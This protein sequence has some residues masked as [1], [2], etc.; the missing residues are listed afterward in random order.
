MLEEARQLLNSGRDVAVGI[1]LDHGRA[2]TREL[3]AGLENVT[4]HLVTSGGVAV[5]EMDVD[6]VLARHP[7]VAVVDEYA[8]TNASGSRNGH[9]WEDVA[10]LL[11]AGIDVLSTVSIQHLASLGDVVSAITDE[12]PADTVPDEIVRRADQIELVDIAPELLRQ[13]LSDGNIY[14]KE[15]VDAALADEFRLGN[16]FALR[17]IAL[18]WLAD[19]VDEGLAKYRASQGITASWPARER[20]V[21]GLTGGPEGDALIR[22]ASRILSRVNGGDL[23]AVHVRRPGHR[24]GEAAEVLAAQG[25]LVTD[26]GGSYH[27]VTGDDASESLLE[28]ARN[29]NATQIVVGVSQSGLTSRLM[30]S[31]VGA[32]VVRGSGDIDVHM[33]SHPLGS[34][35]LPRPAPLALGRARTTAGFIL[36]V[37]L[38]ALATEALSLAPELNL[39]TH[40]L[41]HL[42]G[43]MAVAFI[44]GLWPAV[45]AALLDSLLLNY[46]ETDPVGTFRIDDPQNFFALLVFLGSAIAV[47]LLVGLSA[48]RAR[49]AARARAEAATLAD[50]A[51]DAL[52]EDDT[53]AAFLNKVRKT[54]Q[55]QS[56]GL[57]TLGPDTRGDWALQAY[58]GKAAPPSPGSGDPGLD[59]VELA[60]PETALV[61]SGR[62]LTAGD[63]RLL[64]AYGSHLLLLRQRQSLQLKLRRTAKLAEGNSVRTSILRAVSHDL[65][66]P[67]AG[68]KLAVTAL[69]RQNQRLPEEVKAEMLDTIESYSDRLE[70]LVSNLLDMSRISSGSAAPLTAAVTWRDAIEDALRGVPGGAIRIDLA[71]NMPPI[72]ADLGMLERVIA[73][74]AENALKYAPDSDIVIVGPSSGSGVATIGGRPCGE[75]RIVDHGHGVPP[76]DVLAMFE[77]FQRLDDAPDGLGIGLGLAVAKGFTEAMGGQLAAE[78][79]PGGGLTVVIRLPLSTGS[80]NAHLK[81]R[82]DE[83]HA[84]TGGR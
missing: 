22:R 62:T 81:S 75:L 67:L 18:I 77:P 27:T 7:D 44:G 21:V 6:A 35:G 65:R 23:L 55:V 57:F 37:L 45:V 24:T 54:F 66:T 32:K 31:G 48:R 38:P 30:G 40:V 58:S 63:R 17:E 43:V 13:R 19:R 46:F 80:E 42:T 51:R 11:D 59:A 69:Q 4:Q 72:D 15:R 12:P 60:D 34:H 10:E 53:V 68:I 2:E 33:V 50:L 14:P 61:V 8:H 76:A 74:I 79:T 84:G 29:V 36:A 83:R 25:R 16:L 26:L 41:V 39:A 56:A 47:S 73:N 3:M 49:D 1:A 78:P 71:P 28:F 5:Q 82:T 70:S 52:I 9:R 64:T 20:V